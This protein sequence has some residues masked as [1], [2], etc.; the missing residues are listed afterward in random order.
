MKLVFMLKKMCT[1]RQIAKLTDL[2]HA[3][4]SGNPERNPVRDETL[5]RGVFRRG[6]HNDTEPEECLI[7]AAVNMKS[8]HENSM[9]ADFALALCV[10]KV[11]GIT[12]LATDGELPTSL[13]DF[14]V[15]EMLGITIQPATNH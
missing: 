11:L 3:K 12:T 10:A 1:R 2:R 13:N 8:L 6:V 9:N 4:T 14:C 7:R 5:T 15:A